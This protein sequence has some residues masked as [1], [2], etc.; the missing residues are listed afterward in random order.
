MTTKPIIY[1]SGPMS[2]YPEHNYPAFQRVAAELQALGYTT[3]D[4][5]LTGMQP[6]WEWR[7]YL[8]KDL[9]DMLTKGINTVITL[10]GWEHSK[11]ACLEVHVGRELGMTITTLDAF[12]A[13]HHPTKK[14]VT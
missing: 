2:G 10:D 14:P 3:I 4:P 9:V 12:L 8:V 1:I 6:D 7:D 11:G 5:S 13:L